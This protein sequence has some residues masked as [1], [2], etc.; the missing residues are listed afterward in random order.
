MASNFSLH[1]SIVPRSATRQI[2]QRVDERR[3]AQSH[4]A[5][6]EI[7]DRKHVVRLVNLSRSGAM[8]I[9]S[10]I[11]HIGEPIKL[12]LSGHGRIDG[13]V[14]WVRDGRI[15]VSFTAALD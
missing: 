8:L 9:F 7:G 1:G 15:G 10:L 6:L 4:T 11:P 13:Q 12:Q 14:V 2:D 5:V 3:D